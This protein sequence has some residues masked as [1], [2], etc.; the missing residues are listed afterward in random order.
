MNHFPDFEPICIQQKEE[1][2][3]ILSFYP[4]HSDFNF[5]GLY[6]YNVWNDKMICRFEE[7]LAFLLSDYLTRTRFISFIGHKNVDRKIRTLLEY[8]ITNYGLNMLKLIPEIVV[9]QIRDFK[10]LIVKEDPDNFDYIISVRELTKLRGSKWRDFRKEVNRFRS[11]FEYQFVPIDLASYYI[12]KSIERLILL[13]A[14]QVKIQ[15]VEIELEATRRHM[16]FSDY[17]DCFSFGLYVGGEMVGY[18]LNQIIHDGYYIG[19][20]G[21][22]DRKYDGASRLMEYECAKFFERKGCLFVNLE[23]DLGIE[24]LRNMKRSLNPVGYIKKYV[25]YTNSF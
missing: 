15:D 10:G 18:S 3:G 2:D 9:S 12:R 22:S 13:W 14:Q 24:G 5:V 21:K 25:I 11:K 7:G 1:V 20:F 23:Q 17:H 6:D 4:P 19:H 8:S 16:E